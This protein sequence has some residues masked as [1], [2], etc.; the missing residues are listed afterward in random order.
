M[1]PC[2]MLSGYPSVFQRTLNISCRI[3]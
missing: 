3:V 2:V 1:V